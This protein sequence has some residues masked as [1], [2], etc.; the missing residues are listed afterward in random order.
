MFLSVAA[1]VLRMMRMMRMLFAVQAAAL[2]FARAFYNLPAPAQCLHLD[3]DDGD[4][5]SNHSNVYDNS[6][7]L[8]ENRFHL[9]VEKK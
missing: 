2:S 8:G 4:G 6:G 7:D 1:G 5:G 3:D 9:L